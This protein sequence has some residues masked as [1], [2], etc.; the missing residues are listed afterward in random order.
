MLRLPDVGIRPTVPDLLRYG[1]RQYGD[2]DFV[3]TKNRRLSFAQADRF[4]AA[5][6]KRFLAAGVS[7]G[8]RVGIVLPSSTQFVVSF[9][10]AARIGAVAALFSSLYRPAELRRAMH[11]ADVEILIAPATLFGRD[12]AAQIEDAVPGMASARPPFRLP[13][14][15]FLR[16]VWLEPDGVDG[17]GDG[18]Y[19]GG[20]GGHDDRK[21]A[22]PVSIHPSAPD[23]GVEQDPGDIS[24]DFLASVESA[25]FPSDP[26]LMIWTSGS[27][28]D[29][30]GVV[31]THGVAVRKVSPRVGL[32][33]RNSEPGRVDQPRPALLGSRSPE[34]S[35]GPV[36]RVYPGLPAAL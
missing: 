2:D 32:G 9:L 12:Y 5:L 25:V 28:A 8:S 24:D 30:K 29:P 13:A 20:N 34:H 11:L 14:V 17:G 18:R 4:S 15:P 33:L 31:H 26:L 22:I 36:Y 10:A 19:G 23:E 27:A 16:S 3:V 6:A 7:K 21:W 35:G 1:Y